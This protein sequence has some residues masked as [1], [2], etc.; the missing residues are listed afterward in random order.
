MV[1][2]LATSKAGHDKSKVYVI[3]KEEKEYVYL[4]DGK[5]R[6]IEKPKKKNKKHIQ[7]I[8]HINMKEISEITSNKE[9]YS[10]LNI[11][12]AIKMYCGQ[13]QEIQ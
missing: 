10:D 3:Y 1:G 9:L 11:K 6:T 2:Y 4:V 7:L 8:K 13:K 5:D 12:R